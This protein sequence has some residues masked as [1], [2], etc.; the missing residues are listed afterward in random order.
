MKKLNKVLSVII[1]IIMLASV[2]PTFAL[3]GT[4]ISVGDYI[5]MGMYNDEPIIWRCIS[6]DENGQLMLAD[7]IL[8]LKAFDASGDDLTG[9][10]ARGDEGYRAIAGSNYWADSNI[11]TW[12]NSDAAAGNIVWPCGNAPVTDEVTR[13]QNYYE[14]EAGFLTNFSID[15]RKLI[16]SVSQKSILDAQEYTDMSSYG[17][18]AFK[19]NIAMSDVMQNYDA[20]YS[21]TVT[22]KVF[23]LDVVQLNA[24]VINLGTDYAKGIVSDSAIAYTD[25]FKENGLT[26]GAEWTWWL[27]T[28]VT[29]D[30][31]HSTYVRC[32]YSN[33]TEVGLDYAKQSFHGIRP[34]FYLD[35]VNANI[36]LGEGTESS[37]YELNSVPTA[38][39][40]Y[41]ATVSKYHENI[42][43]VSGNVGTENA[44]KNATIVLIPKA[45]YTT[46]LTAKHITNATVADDGSYNAKFK[47]VIGED[48]VLIV[49][50]N[51]TESVYSLTA[52]KDAGEELV[53]LD[54]SLDE[55]N[56]VNVNLKNKYIDAT[57]AKLI[58]A[59]YTDSRLENA[60]VIDFE[61]A[62]GEN[63]EIQSYISESAV[64]GTEVKVF[65]WNNFVDMKPLSKEE[66]KPIPEIAEVSE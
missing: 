27:R 37:P 54:I 60:R 63:G 41:G 42:I 33:G 32:V 20:A 39:S 13:F 64:E 46:L 2:M 58:M 17:T 5:V 1:C 16:K 44:G 21:E 30:V 29:E 48:D 3:A 6:A 53:E 52:P 49:K 38:I 9:S 65:L 18:E 22:D 50:I 34:A 23:L 7:K 25:S 14:T 45:S 26:Y 15:E 8:S 19:Y 10:H 57:T 55:N 66:C 24:L 35:T 59:A 51:G 62:F 47:A 12:L 43:N 56:K 40:E 28:P 61:L 36:V 4:G 11:R 31:C